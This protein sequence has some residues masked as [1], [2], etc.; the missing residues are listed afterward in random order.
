MR[1]FCVMNHAVDR[2]GGVFDAYR[3]QRFE[4]LQFAAS[5]LG[6]C[7]RSAT[8]NIV[9]IAAIIVRCTQPQGKMAG[10]RLWALGCVATAAAAAAPAIVNDEVVID[11][12]RPL[13]PRRG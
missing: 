7:G 9:R 6:S 12:V 2:D 8:F 4:Q 3:I 1:T 10:G 5:M 11:M 13:D